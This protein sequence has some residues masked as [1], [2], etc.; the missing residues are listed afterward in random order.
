MQISG[1]TNKPCGSGLARDSG[2]SD[3]INVEC[4]DAIASRLTPTRDLWSMQIS[5]KTN[6]P[7]GSGLARDSGV[8]DDINVG[9]ND[10][11]AGKPAP[12]VI[13]GVCRSQARRTNLVGVS[14]LAKAKGQATLMLNVM[15]SS[16]ASPLPQ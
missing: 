4:N 10:P 5:G 11:I 12:T 13:W 6:K 9:C 2:V 8:S 3:D 14:L 7:C 15:A 1:K 16:R